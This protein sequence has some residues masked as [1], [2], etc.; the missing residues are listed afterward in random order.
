[1]KSLRY[2]R[3]AV[4]AFLS[5]LMI[6]GAAHA[7]K[8]PAEDGEKWDPTEVLGPLADRGETEPN[9]TAAT[10]N[11]FACGDVLTPAAINPGGDFDFI[12][13]TA[14]IGQVITF[15]TDTDGGASPVPDTFI[16]LIAADGTTVLASDDDSGPG[17]YSLLSHN[18]TYT[19]TYYGKIRA[20][21]ATQVGSYKAFVTC[22]AAPPNA[23]D[24]RDFKG[25]VQTF[26]TPVPIP[27]NLPAGVQVGQINTTNDLTR[28]LDV[29][30]SVKMAHTFIG[31]LVMQVTYDVE[32]DGTAE[33]TSTILCRP[34]RATCVGGTGFGCASNLLCANTYT[35]SDAAANQL[36]V[37][38]AGCGTTSTNIASG[39]FRTGTNGTPLSV[40]DNFDKGGCFKLFISDNAA[41]DL[42]TVCEWAV[43]TLNQAVVPVELSTWGAI[44]SRY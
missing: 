30:V 31:D 26:P 2:T 27:D 13:F 40:F 17:L 4:C 41:G 33:A 22:Q 42:G 43:Y 28:F 34:G 5:L 44:K 16:D 9:N 39:C 14:T 11:P 35:F 1:M 36:G 20:F 38:P 3:P 18:A 10:A 19:G 15:G 21:N 37:A 12:V 32:C 8:D 23:C 6:A 7:Q 25:F 29:I 24:T